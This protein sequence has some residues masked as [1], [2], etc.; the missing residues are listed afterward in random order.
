METYLVP[1]YGEET[2][3]VIQHVAGRTEPRQRCVSVWGDIA[4]ESCDAIL[5]NEGKV[6]RIGDKCWCC[7]TPVIAFDPIL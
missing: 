4:C 3:Y 7:G 6:L 2:H 1:P 5:A